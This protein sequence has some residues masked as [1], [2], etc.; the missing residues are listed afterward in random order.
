M[1]DGRRRCRR[2]PSDTYFFGR[3]GGPD[4]AP[5][6]AAAR[7]LPRRVGPRHGTTRKLLLRSVAGS[8]DERQFAK[9]CA[10]MHPR[11]QPPSHGDRAIAYNKY[12]G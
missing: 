1:S 8:I 9:Q 10:T 2:L 7:R 4:S 3:K 11:F 6:T 5:R 12:D